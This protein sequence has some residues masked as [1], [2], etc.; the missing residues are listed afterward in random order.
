MV[1]LS[2]CH[3]TMDGVP[4]VQPIQTIARVPCSGCTARTPSDS[5]AHM[6][7]RIVA[8]I[9]QLAAAH[10]VDDAE[11][12]ISRSHGW[13]TANVGSSCAV[14]LHSLMWDA[15]GI[16]RHQRRLTADAQAEPGGVVG[17]VRCCGSIDSQSDTDATMPDPG[18]PF[19]PLPP[20]RWVAETDWS[21]FPNAGT[22]L[23]QEVEHPRQL[24]TFPSDSLQGSAGML[25][26][27]VGTSSG[28]F[29]LWDL[30]GSVLSGRSDGTSGRKH[31]VAP[32]PIRRSCSLHDHSPRN[33][34][35]L[36][37]QCLDGQ[38]PLCRGRSSPLA[39]LL[40]KCALDWTNEQRASAALA[41]VACVP[42][43]GNTKTGNSRS[44]SDARL[45]VAGT[46][47]SR[48]EQSSS[49][50]LLTTVLTQPLVGQCSPSLTT[51][52]S[53]AA[54]SVGPGAT[55]PHYRI[56]V[57][58][59]ACVNI[60]TREASSSRRV[61]T[62][63]LWRRLVNR[64]FDLSRPALFFFE[65]IDSSF[66]M[67]DRFCPMTSSTGFRTNLSVTG[68]VGVYICILIL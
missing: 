59:E 52:G 53:M 39:V 5:S 58:C 27:K 48:Q 4:V 31:A 9:P 55:W 12:Q 54:T 2:H 46:G 56:R 57:A 32:Q 61:W 63:S 14:S 67:T 17:A 18:S 62:A 47:S 40:R 28:Q 65:M 19:E 13:N 35:R 66:R 51:T 23:F 24:N 29:S 15:A 44:S 10:V 21:D 26:G 37:L 38:S 45:R 42:S 33:S 8:M 64:R 41:D 49:A 20:V 7:A 68:H 30:L 6:H 60:C 11:Y 16:G 43:V 50:R 22:L 1:C 34:C 3:R 25:T 36:V